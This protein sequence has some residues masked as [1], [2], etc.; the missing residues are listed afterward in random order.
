LLRKAAIHAKLQSLV[1]GLA[2]VV[3]AAEAEA[4]LVSAVEDSSPWLD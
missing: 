1:V 2:A 3:L 4:V